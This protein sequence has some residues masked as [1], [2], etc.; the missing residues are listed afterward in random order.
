MKVVILAGGFGTRLSEY[1]ETVPKPMVEIGGKPILWHIMNF[2]AQYNYKNFVVAL[3]HKGDIIKAE[4]SFARHL[5]LLRK[6]ADVKTVTMHGDPLSSLDNRDMW[7]SLSLKDFDLLGEAFLTINYKDIYYFTDSGRN[8]SK[9]SAN[10]RDNVIT[11]KVFSGVNSTEDLCSFIDKNRES[12][13]SIVTH[14]ER[15][16]SSYF[17]WPMQY[18]FD[19][20][21]IILKLLLEKFRN[22]D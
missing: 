5:S 6:I 17:D 18:I 3:G 14:P 22:K 1:T 8:W 16:S 7:K 4:K 10:F 13:I 11:D 9:D 21:S 20:L 19:R 12:S 2:Y 15:W